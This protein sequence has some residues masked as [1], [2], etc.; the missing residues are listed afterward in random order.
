MFIRSFGY[1]MECSRHTPEFQLIFYSS[2]AQGQLE[3]F[4]IVSTR[5]QKGA[6][7][8]PRRNQFNMTSL[9]RAWNGGICAKK[10]NARGRYPQ[11][12][13][14]EM[15]TISTE[16]TLALNQTLSIFRPIS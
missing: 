5:C 4:G 11:A 12:M 7:T 8:T 1:P 14:F 9:R 15:D 16:E 3:T 6:R 2:I 10:M 13:L